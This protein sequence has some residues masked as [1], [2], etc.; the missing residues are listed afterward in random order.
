MTYQ[1]GDPNHL[2]VHNQLTADVG[3]LA[4][5][6]SVE[7]VLPDTAVLGST[8][9]VDDHNLIKDALDKIASEGVGDP[10][11]PA[12]LS[13]FAIKG[14]TPANNYAAFTTK[15]IGGTRVMLHTFTGDTTYQT[16][17]LSDAD[18]EAEATERMIDTADVPMVRVISKDPYEFTFTVDKVGI[19]IGAVIAAGGAGGASGWAT[20]NPNYQPQGAPGGAGGVLLSSL[21]NPCVFLPFT[22]T[23]TVSVGS[24]CP[25]HAS[26]GLSLAQNTTLTHD[27]T[28]YVITAVGGGSGGSAASNS[29]YGFRAGTG[30]S[31]GAPLLDYALSTDSEAAKNMRGGWVPGQGHPAGRTEGY[32][33][34]GAGGAGGPGYDGGSMGTAVGGD[35][36]DLFTEFTLDANDAQAQAW[37]GLFTDPDNPGYVAGGGTGRKGTTSSPISVSVR[38]KGGGGMSNGTTNRDALNHTG[39]GGGAG[40]ASQVGGSGANGAVHIVVPL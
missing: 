20:A 6:M 30:G 23:W 12:Q 13:G 27:A 25:G 29:G 34:P 19:L 14:A 36:V 35:G 2:A 21:D 3:D 31:A 8:G 38:S 32:A 5:N 22:G 9:H 18:V 1:E 39:S 15:Q 10:L 4:S 7:V 26:Y 33:A 16:R 28:G 11:Q 24:R 37:R 17:S 40:Q